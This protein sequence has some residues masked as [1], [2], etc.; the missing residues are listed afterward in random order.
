MLP[1]RFSDAG[2][3]PEYN[4][5]DA[6]LWFFEAVRAYLAN[7]GD[8][9]F[10]GK[11]LYNVLADIVRWHECGMRYGIKVDEDGLVVAGQP[12]MQL[13]WMDAKVGDCVVTPCH[14]K[15]VE[16]QA[17]WYNA[18]RVMEDVS[19]RLSRGAPSRFRDLAERTA[20]SFKE[21]F[22]NPAGNCLYDVI[23]GDVR[24]DSI[25]P[26]QIFAVSLFQKWY[27]RNAH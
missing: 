2:E 15:A 10:I 25:R 4:T 21:L 7:T 8:L 16:I 13:T 24:D 11:E 19:D 1:N 3:A 27:R 22:W 9:D 5:A 20:A 12:G 14:G 23:N 18:L 26:N 6:T 17:L